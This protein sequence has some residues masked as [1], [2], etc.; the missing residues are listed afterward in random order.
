MDQD[1]E[2]VGWQVCELV[3]GSKKLIDSGVNSWPKKSV[4][5]FPLQFPTVVNRNPCN[6]D[7]YTME[8]QGET[9]WLLLQMVEP[10][11]SYV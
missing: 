8:N 9:I 4:I 5:G 3:E 10:S 1:D 6:C 7:N 2:F 11:S